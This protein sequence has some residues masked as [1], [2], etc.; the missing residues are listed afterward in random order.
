MENNIRILKQW[1]HEANNILIVAHFNPDGDAIG[2]ALAFKH[3][4]SQQNKSIHVAAPNDFPENLKWMKDAELVVNFQKD[5]EKIESLVS[6]AD[7]MFCMD[8]QSLT[9]TGDMEPLLTAASC[10]KVLID[11]HL[12][13]KV[14]DFDLIFSDYQKSST[15]E[16]LFYI[17]TLMED[18]SLNKDAAAC[19]Y[20]G[21]STDTGSF[22][23]SCRD[24]STFH[25]VAEL[26]SLGID[27]VDIHRKIFD[28]FSENRLRL[29]G[30]S[31]STR[32]KVLPEFATAY[33][34]LTEEDLNRF[35]YQVGDSE[36]IVNFALSMK[37]VSFAALFTER[38][39]RIRISFRSK[40][41]IDTNAFA[42][43]HFQGGGHRN[44]SGGTSYDKMEMTLQKFESL[45][46]TLNMD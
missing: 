27:T 7:M 45:L 30:Y 10:K 31:L 21:I 24:A 37:E 13:P 14:S 12:D 43:N 4:L 18:A 32:M 40:G 19:L 2:S 20:A 5:K 29:L 39:K 6:E 23:Y 33:I 46:P 8:F 16:L 36:G 22:S 9:R 11:H 44:A 15:S 3:I 26:I 1:L 41:N 28:N 25:C 35:H 34:Y 38:E 17:I 42:R